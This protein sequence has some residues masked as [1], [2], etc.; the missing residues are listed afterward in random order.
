MYTGVYHREVL[1]ND[2]FNNFVRNYELAYWGPNTASYQIG[3]MYKT[4]K[5][6][7]EYGC[8]TCNIYVYIAY[9]EFEDDFLDEKGDEWLPLGK[10]FQNHVKLYIR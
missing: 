6:I 9:S 4:R 10:S 2:E 5:N 3:S 7:C 8:I 1:L